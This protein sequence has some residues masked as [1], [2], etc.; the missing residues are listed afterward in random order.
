[1]N[2]I[3][4]L[5]SIV[6][7]KNSAE[8]YQV[9]DTQKLQ[10]TALLSGMVSSNP[11]L[12]YILI[13]N[14]AKNLQGETTTTVTTSPATELPSS[15]TTDGSIEK[16]VNKIIAE[17]ISPAMLRSNNPK[18]ESLKSEIELVTL[19]Y[20]VK[21]QLQKLE[22]CL[23]KMET[24]IKHPKLSQLDFDTLSMV[25][26]LKELFYTK[27]V[28][29]KEIELLRLIES[30]AEF[31]ASILSSILFSAHIENSLEVVTT[32]LEALGYY[33]N[34]DAAMVTSTSAKEKGTIAKTTSVKK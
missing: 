11:L 1:M 17:R 13:E 22:A 5:F 33:T 16:I 12:S 26:N 27:N 9:N 30:S 32:K 31:N 18:I 8:K 6:F 15:T 19:P 28:I 34:M 20:L 23:P 2:P 10:N 29:H 25:E 4:L 7:A 14:E 3:N 24:I 21:N